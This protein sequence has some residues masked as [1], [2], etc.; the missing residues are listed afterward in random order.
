MLLRPQFNHYCEV[1]GRASALVAF[2]TMASLILAA[3]AVANRLELS[4]TNSDV[5]FTPKNGHSTEIR[6]LEKAAGALIRLSPMQTLNIA[7]TRCRKISLRSGASPD[8]LQLRRRFDDR[9]VTEIA[10]LA[11]CGL[12]KPLLKEDKLAGFRKAALVAVSR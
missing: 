12:P 11:L 8:A 6:A 9:D 3:I 10:A 5:C 2:V 4:A 7:A 1:V